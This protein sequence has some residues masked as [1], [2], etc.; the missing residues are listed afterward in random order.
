MEIEDHEDD[1]TITYKNKDVFYFNPELSNG[2]TGDELIII[3]HIFIM[4]RLFFK[5]LTT[6]S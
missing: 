3:P 1:D 4:V 2:L 5:F 6:D